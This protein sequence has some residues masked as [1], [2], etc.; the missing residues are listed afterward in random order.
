MQEK[1]SN[2]AHQLNDKVAN[3]FFYR[4]GNQ[5]YTEPDP[6]LVDDIHDKE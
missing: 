2:H 1:G 6:Y 5:T 4:Q 3:I